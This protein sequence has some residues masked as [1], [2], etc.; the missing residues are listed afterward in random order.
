MDLQWSSQ[1]LVQLSLFASREPNTFGGAGAQVDDVVG[2][3]HHLQVV[4]DHDQRMP[5][6]SRAS[7][8]SS[9]CTTSAKCRPVV[10][11]SS[12]NSVRPRLAADM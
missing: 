2:G 12:R 3:L 7:K 10:G 4:L 1:L 5:D 6:A 8:Q 11:S 9:S